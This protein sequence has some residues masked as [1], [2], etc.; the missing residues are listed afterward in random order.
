MFRGRFLYPVEQRAFARSLLPGGELVVA[1]GVLRDCVH[2]CDGE[3]LLYSGPHECGY[4][5]HP[6]R[7]T[8]G[9]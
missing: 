7:L 6:G 3:C 8:E 5:C 9:V 2:G 1:T 4:S